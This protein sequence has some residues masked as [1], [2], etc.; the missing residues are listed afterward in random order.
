MTRARA[1]PY[2]LLPKTLFFR[3]FTY[4][5]AWSEIIYPKIKKMK[6]RTLVKYSVVG[7]GAAWL[8]S[9]LQKRTQL[10]VEKECQVRIAVLLGEGF[11][12]GEAYIPIGYMTNQGAKITVVGP[13]K[14]IVKAYNSEFTIRIDKSIAEVSVDDFDALILPGGHAPSK[15]RENEEVVA[16]ARDF[17][18][19]GKPTAA[20]CHGPQ[21]LITAGVLNGKTS[22]GVEG[23]RGELEAA[24][25]TYLDQSLVIDGNLITSRSPSDL[26]DF[27]MAIAEAVRK[28]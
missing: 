20:I 1:D 25:V 24:G 10:A 18:H 14:V 9:S 13:Q 15:L 3:T 22:T 11:H 27:S 2:S 21:V 28:D 23:I 16:F 8:F 17:F 7:M 5:T 6:I 12:D 26:N 19:S 4:N